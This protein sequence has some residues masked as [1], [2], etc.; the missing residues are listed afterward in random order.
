MPL[1]NNLSANRS[2][3]ADIATTSD[4]NLLRKALDHQPAWFVKTYINTTIEGRYPAMMKA[5][6]AHGEM[7]PGVSK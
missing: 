2:L 4:W 1:L 7:E 5:L 3:P 6:A